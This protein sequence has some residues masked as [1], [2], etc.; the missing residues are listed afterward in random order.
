MVERRKLVPVTADLYFDAGAIS[1]LRDRVARLLA[2]GRSASPSE[3]RQTLEVSRKYLIPLLEHL[4]SMG[5]TRRRGD[6][7]V[8]K[9]AATKP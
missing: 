1:A 3:F 5:L 8:L 6:T 9:Q 2:D 4:D 7:R